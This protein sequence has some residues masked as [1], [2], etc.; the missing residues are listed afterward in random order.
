MG[1]PISEDEFADLLRGF[2]HTS[3]R[4]EAQP[5]Y[6]I[7][8]ERAEFG[9]FLAGS[10]R[11]PMEIG[12]WREWL[13][14]AAAMTRLG[15]QLSRVRVIP[16]TGPTDYQRWLI[17]ADPWYAAAGVD[18]RYIRYRQAKQISLPL[19]MSLRDD[20]QLLDGKLLIKMLF[21]RDGEADSKILTTDSVVIAQY[22]R[23]RDLAVASATPAARITAA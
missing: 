12:W 9:R 2:D 18:I 6:A 14:E 20:W 16:D 5:V 8:E 17:W 19:A 3:F 11:S 1:R 23:W 7:S 4:L 21:T 13:D 10:P 15:K 22:Q